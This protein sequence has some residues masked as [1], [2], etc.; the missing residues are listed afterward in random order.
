ML[1][2]KYSP[3]HQVNHR[4]HRIRSCTTPTGSVVQLLEQ[5]TSDPKV[6]NLNPTSAAE[7]LNSQLDVLSV[8]TYNQI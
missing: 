8:E 4:H 2:Q 1:E 7:I 3:A 6:M 5:Q